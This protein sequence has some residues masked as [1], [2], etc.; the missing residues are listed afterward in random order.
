MIS[1]REAHPIAWRIKK[2][3]RL[4]MRKVSGAVSVFLV[5]LRPSQLVSHSPLS[6]VISGLG[7]V[8]ELIKG[9]GF[10]RMKGS[11]MWLLRKQFHVI[12]KL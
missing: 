9:G 1:L 12:N 11:T 3:N 8:S 2:D 10:Q 6:I 4:L 5:Q 7:E